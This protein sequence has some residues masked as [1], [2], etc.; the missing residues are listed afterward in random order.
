MVRH[1]DPTLA[2]RIG[3]RA[4]AES[5]RPMVAYCAGC[6]LALSATGKAS[7]H[8]ADFLLDPGWRAEDARRIPGHWLRYANRLRV[9]W[10]LGRLTPLGPGVEG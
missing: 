6:Q 9:K 8:L 7:S 2:E 1:V 3:R 4:A 5:A 10:A